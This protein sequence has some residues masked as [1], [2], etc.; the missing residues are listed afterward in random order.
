[1]T[2]QA[3]RLPALQIRR[4]SYALGA[5]VRGVDLTRHLDDATVAAI[6]AAWLE[7]LLLCFP[8]QNLTNAQL[9]AFAE[10]FGE[11]EAIRPDEIVRRDAEG[12]SPS[13]DILSNRP[14]NG[15]PWDGFKN[16]DTWHTDK[17]FTL[18]PTSATIIACKEIPEVG[19]D[20]MFANAYLAYETLSP[21]FQG[22][23]DGLWAI[24]EVPARRESGN[25]ATAHPLV[26]VHPE[27]GRKALYLGA[28][29]YRLHEIV[30]LTLNE[31]RPLLDFLSAHATT[32]EFTYRHRWSVDDVVMWDNRALQHVALCD[33]DLRNDH[34]HLIRTAVKGERSGYHVTGPE[35]SKRPVD[36]I[37]R[38]TPALLERLASA[39][40]RNVSASAGS[41]A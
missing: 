4:L 3:S 11:L 32:I 30:G 23:I 22:I 21:T 35:G 8:G 2:A 1:M 14:L 20:T 17:S 27:T 25:T 36:G 7:H 18:Y 29:G 10:R 31:S 15:Q 12:G 33:Y 39:A 9:L 26:R 24:H 6:R 34:R 40:A 41:N 5:K 13:I 28:S 19:G 16:G 38:F 37:P